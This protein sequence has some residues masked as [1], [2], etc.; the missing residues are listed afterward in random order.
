M[1]HASAVAHDHQV[2]AFCGSS[3]RGKSTLAGRLAAHGM[4]PLADDL[5]VIALAADRP[6]VVQRAKRTL[7]TCAEEQAAL[8][9]TSAEVSTDRLDRPFEGPRLTLGKVLFLHRIE[10]AF[11]EI[12]EQPL[13][14]A[15]ALVRLLENSFA[16][17]DRPDLWRQL[18]EENGRLAASVPMVRADIP[19]GLDQVGGC[20]GALRFPL[21]RSRATAPQ[22]GT[23]AGQQGRAQADYPHVP[24]VVETATG[25]VGLA[26]AGG[27]RDPGRLGSA[28]QQRSRRIA[29]KPRPAIIRRH[30]GN[31]PGHEHHGQDE[32]KSKA[33]THDRRLGGNVRDILRSYRRA[34]ARKMIEP[35]GLPRILAVCG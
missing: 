23:Y 28:R 8:L 1:L 4:T 33:T 9:R 5:L 15:D 11:P 20:R 31:E 10:A 34:G 13:G 21:N 14:R 2:L 27:R 19:E 22:Q 12:V 25:G 32:R 17:L 35:I 24:V 6:E 26:L 29:R 3:G 16:E 18:W 30:T 7:R